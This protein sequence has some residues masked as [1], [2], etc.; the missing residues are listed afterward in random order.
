VTEI[1][2]T[3]ALPLIDISG[4]ATERGLQYGTK[5]KPYI[6]Q[7]ISNYKKAFASEGIEWNQACKAASSY[8]PLLEKN[9]QDLFAEIIAIAKGAE[10]EVEEILALNCRTEI[11]Y[12][13]NPK[14]DKASDGC[15]GAIALPSATASGK[16]LHG[17]NWDWRDECAETSIV[18][19][20]TPEKGPQI[21]TQTEAGILARC[22]INSSGLALTGNFLK[23]E[24]DNQPGGIPIPF[25]RRHILEQENYSN[26]IRVVLNTPKS[27]STNLMISH[28]DGEAINLEAVPGETFWIQPKDG[29]LVHA[30]H[31]ESVPALTKV[32]DEGLKVAPCSLHRGRRVR[33][34]LEQSI[35]KLD[36]NSFISAFSDKFDNPYGVCAEPD[37]GPG[38]DTS[39]TVATIMMDAADGKMWIAPRPYKSSTFTE[40][41]FT[42]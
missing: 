12:G 5:A 2:R 28:R 9:E 19:R 11:I 25:V 3:T 39:S 14:T 30:N 34:S 21:L 20:I 13:I 10:V 23:C 22:G 1:L 16:L 42:D 33:Q 7:A 40:Y 38:G 29:L 35:G 17:Q 4:T 6:L 36:Q 24:R 15:T 31:F 27:F 41:N 8:I 18:L 32:T 26:A 37:H